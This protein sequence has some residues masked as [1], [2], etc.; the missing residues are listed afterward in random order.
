MHRKHISWVLVLVLAV[1]FVTSTPK[2]AAQ[3][4]STPEERAQ[5]VEI[6]HKLE[7]S[8]LDDSVNKQETRDN[9]DN[10]GT[11]NP[12]TTTR[13]N[14]GTTTWGQERV[15]KSTIGIFGVIQNLSGHHERR[16]Y[17]F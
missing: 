13:D 5:W 17:A 7:S 11:D 16:L 9:P 10:P 4:T 14:L 3:G 8:P 1:F 12:G 2:A 6:T 15:K